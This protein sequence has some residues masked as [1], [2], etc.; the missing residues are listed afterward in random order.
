MADE[1]KKI[2][3][4][5]IEVNGDTYYLNSHQ[6]SKTQCALTI[7]QH[8]QGTNGTENLSFNGSAFVSV[9]IVPATGGKFSG[10][11][12]VPE[13]QESDL[14]KIDKESVVNY[15]DIEQFLSSLVGIPYYFWD[16]STLSN[17]TDTETNTLQNI[18]IVVG[19]LNNFA[20]FNS[21]KTSVKPC[22]YVGING[23]SNSNNYN[24]IYFCNGKSSYYTLTDTA[25]KT[26]I[27]GE[28]KSFEELFDA[29][30]A[31]HIE[32]ASDIQ[33]IS[34]K[35]TRILNGSITVPNAKHAKEAAKADYATN[36]GSAD[37]SKK[38]DYATTADKATNDGNGNN[39]V[40]TYYRAGSCIGALKPENAAHSIFLGSTDPKDVG[41]LGDIWI[42]YTTPLAKK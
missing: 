27:N 26:L 36:A 37:E 12:L 1:I 41:N 42:K 19:S 21:K 22:L 38:S 34:S 13:Q 20:K 33:Q 39:I 11:I 18:N 7:K 23:D 32:L 3:Q 10:P 6:A 16:G 8:K 17:Q 24:E 40:N 35:L 25:I 30:T 29:N 15:G 28:V 31:N 4:S 5:P 2:I 9:D 14:S